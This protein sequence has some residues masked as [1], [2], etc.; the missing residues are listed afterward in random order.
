MAKLIQQFLGPLNKLQTIEYSLMMIFTVTT[1]IH[2]RAGIWALIA[3][4]LFTIVKAIWSKKIGNSTL[5]K[6]SR[7]SLCLVV[8]FY[9]I[10]AISSSYSS[11]P[12]EAWSTTLVTM[13]PMLLLPL[14]FLVSDMGYLRKKH[15][16]T[17]TILLAATL[18]L[19]FFILIIRALVRF[20]KGEIPFFFTYSFEPMHHN[21]IAMYLVVAIAL[22]YID[23]I[24]PRASV[25]WERCRLVVL[26][27]IVLLMFYVLAT[28]SRSGLIMLAV[29]TFIFLVHAAI[30]RK[31]WIK[32]G[33]TVICI[34][35]AIGFTYLT[36]PQMYEKVIK[37]SQKIS[38][39][40]QGN[41][42][43]TFWTCSL[44]IFESRMLIGYGCDG[45]KDLV[46]DCCESHDYKD[47]Y[48]NSHNQY[49]E[50][51]LA[52]GFA[53]LGVM[54]LFMA[55]PVVVAIRQKPRNLP[56]ILFTLTYAGCIFFESTF[57][58][59]MGLLFIFWWYG[60]LQLNLQPDSPTEEPLK[61]RTSDEA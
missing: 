38:S 51:A 32:T 31:Q 57:L 45:Y 60:I 28:N 42:R 44:K 11:D 23:F 14:I 26:A 4:T 58:R 46:K 12:H 16:T 29:L 18:S 49:I 24:K 33:I 15:R 59:Q 8:L 19:R 6:G 48:I 56:V 2:W 55:W 43:T 25:Q 61:S 36:A 47:E 27:D 54:L 10:F 30:V 9:L 52:T 13:L 34:F 35:L 40:E 37:T 21:Y 1:A 39:G 41:I 7:I 17:L 20:V 50:T 22:L 5:S 3:L 53:G